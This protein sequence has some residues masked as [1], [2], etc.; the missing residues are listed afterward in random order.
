MTGRRVPRDRAT[1]VR[2][3]R[4]A[5]GLQYSGNN[6]GAVVTSSSIT[7]TATRN[8]EPHQKEFS[9]TP[10]TIGPIA[11]PAERLVTHT[12]MARVRCFGSLNILL[13]SARLDG[14]RVAAAMPSK[15]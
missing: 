8:T 10:P 14:A 3:N 9:S 1:L 2:S 7:G 12:E 5:W 11:P 15:A 13:S 4:T 6:N